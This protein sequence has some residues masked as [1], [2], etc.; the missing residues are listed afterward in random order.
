MLPDANSC[1]IET[2]RYSPHIRQAA[3]SSR[4]PH[5]RITVELLKST[6]VLQVDPLCLS[7]PLKALFL[8]VSRPID[9]KSTCRH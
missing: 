4:R 1:C 9:L 6:W 8:T 7:F 2:Q 3:L 5:E